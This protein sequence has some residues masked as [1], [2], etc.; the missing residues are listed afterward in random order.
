[1]TTNP[2][3]PANAVLDG[4]YLQVSAKE[5]RILAEEQR[6]VRRLATGRRR[7]Q[8]TYP[9]VG[10]PM[11]P[12]QRRFTLAWE[13]T[14]EMRPALEELL[15]VPGLHPLILWRDEPLA[16]HADGSR[17]EFHLPNGWVLA[18]DRQIPPDGLSPDRFSP[19][20][21]VGLDGV[22]LTYSSHDEATYAAG[23]PAAGE[24]WF[25]IPTSGGASLKLA[26][27][28][29]AGEIV[30]ARVVPVYQVYL[31]PTRAEQTFAGPLRE[32]RE[33]TLLEA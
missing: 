30:Y 25:S 18:I 24:V 20:V 10:M 5:W 31:A 29:A 9:G 6:T 4:V 28:P 32:P 17:A 8:V 14:G 16:W 19:A 12:A 13:H 7:E 23:T 1:M 22:V 15:A 11:V 26:T 2:A 3:V 27:P 21:K 33:I